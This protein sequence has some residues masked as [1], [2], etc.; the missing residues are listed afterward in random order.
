MTDRNLIAILR[1]LTPEDALPVAEALVEAG[2]TRIEVPLNSPR[3]LESIRTM[4]E[5][6]GRDALIGAGTVLT[7]QDV[8][9]VAD[10]GGRLIVSPNFDAEVVAE[11][12]RLGLLSFPGVLTPTEC[13][14][15]LK[16]RADGLKIF[17]AFQ[18]GIE[19]LVAIRAVL[20]KGAQLYMVGGVGPEAFGDWLK[21]GAN[22]F[23]LGS[24]LYKPGMSAAEVGSRARRMVAAWDHATKGVAV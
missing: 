11:T 22:G 13:F 17:P 1:G 8:R 23:G 3:P 10:A 19:G 12:K 14:A 21:A 5:H 9:E 2:I 20:P 6:L 7:P 18:M 16:A 15:A 4:A 24:S